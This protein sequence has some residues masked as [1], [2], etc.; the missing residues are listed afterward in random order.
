MASAASDKSHDKSPEKHQDKYHLKSIHEEIDL[1]DRK[2]AHLLK[3]EKFESDADRDRATR[4]LTL[5]R[6]AL[7]LTAQR[8]AGEGIE[9]KQAEL[10][11][12]LRPK[13]EDLPVSD[14]PAEETPA[15]TESAP[16]QTF[17]VST[18][19]RMSGPYEGT[20][21]DWQASVRAYMQKKG[22]A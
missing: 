10:P 7:V 5:K 18:A 20:S 3:Y 13:A 15:P 17:M 8:L 2:L 22:R 19:S 9:F 4:K 16:A 14:A 11:R 6:D 21:L 12:S 1:F